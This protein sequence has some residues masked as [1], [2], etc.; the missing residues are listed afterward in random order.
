M[1]L[2]LKTEL[3]SSITTPSYTHPPKTFSELLDS[4]YSVLFYARNESG[5]GEIF[6]KD[7]N[8]DMVKRLSKKIV[9]HYKLS[10]VSRQAIAI[11]VAKWIDCLFFARKLVSKPHS[12]RILP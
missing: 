8:N 2:E 6:F 10:D 7:S 4:G 3:I 11:F 9:G 1:C 12:S 5:A